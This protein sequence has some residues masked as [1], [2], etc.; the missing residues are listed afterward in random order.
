MLDAI[1]LAI[2]GIG[3]AAFAFCSLP[4]VLKAYHTKSTRDISKTFIIFSIIGNVCSAMYI[5]YTNI[6][7]GIWQYPQYFNYS[8]AL[9]FIIILAYLKSKY[10][11]RG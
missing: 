3:A 11:K 2:G 1:M 8:L 10:D 7:A 4:Q 5:L 6:K 9:I